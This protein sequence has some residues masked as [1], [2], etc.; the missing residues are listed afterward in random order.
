MSLRRFFRRQAWD[1]ECA[2]ELDAYLAQEID[3]NLARGMTTEQART[4]AY[5]KLGNPTRIREEIY[6][7]NSVG[8]L[9]SIWQDLRYGARLLRRNPTFA[10]VAVLTLALGTGA[11]SAIF[12]LVNAVRLRTLPVA[13][14][15]ELVEVRVKVEHGLTGAFLGRRPSLSNPLWERVRAEQRV[16]T[17]M[18]AWGATRWNL[19]SGGEVRRAQGMY[20]SGDYFSTLG[21]AAAVGRTIL[22]SD[23][24][25]GCAAPGAVISDSFWRRDYGADPSIVG[26]QILL[27]GHRVDILGVTP[28]SFFGTEVGRSF[29]VAM[30]ICAEPM[31]TG[32]RSGID[33]PDV[34]FLAAFGRLKPGVTIERATAQLNAISSGIFAT[35]V[36]PRYDAADA[37][38]YTQATLYAQPAA[39]GVSSLR[40]NYDDSLSILL[41]VTALV[42]LIA[43]A[44]LANL[45]LARGSA[46]EREIAI[47]LAIGATRERIVRQLLSESLLIAALGAAAGM[48]LA[49]WFSR[50]LVG[51]L[52][53]DGNQLFVDLTPDWRVFAFTAGVAVLACV[54]FGLAPAVRATR[55]SPGA[56]MKGGS[57]GL[58]DSRE[59][60]GVRRALVS[61]QVALSVVLVV[62]ALLFARTLLNLTRLD[63]GFRQDGVLVASVDFRKAGLTGAALETA[64]ND[65]RDRLAAIPGVDGVARAY[66]TPVSGNFWNNRIAIRGLP[67]K[68]PI[69]NFNSVDVEYFRVLSTPIVAGRAFDER[70]TRA[71]PKVAVVSES[72]VRA[73]MPKADALGQSF[74]ITAPAGEPQPSYQIVG[75]VR[76]TKYGSLRES[77]APIAFLS[78]RQADEPDDGPNYVMHASTTLAA[79]SAAATR[80]IAAMNP[81]LTVQYQTLRAQLRAS[82]LRERLMATLSGFFGGLAVLIATVGLY[83]V[84]SY[85]V[86]RR[87]VEIGIRMALGADRGSVVR[88]I[89]R[90]AAWLLLAGAA[91]GVALTLYAGR[92]AGALL[93]D[94][95]PSDP[96][97]IALA[98]A[99]LGSVCLL[100]SWLPARRA[101]RLHPTAALRED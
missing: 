96:S 4:A 46:R 17:S 64:T 77:F 36:S 34:W 58:T 56:S 94:L 1:A 41:G 70:D 50:F 24:V 42:L 82:L 8:P 88:L 29:D 74:Q 28:P 9:E 45:M 85:S 80:T 63:P 12:Q 25:R 44:N 65:L 26:R 75:V 21:V 83:G 57:R 72:F 69:V 60:F 98:L 95:R 39:T 35:T 81:A 49:S 97:T 71:T 89:V 91:A 27:D 11:N 66:T 5:R 2:R 47:R 19:A 90:E 43:C 10:I 23:D 7:M 22:P 67:Q 6:T 16:F 31:F 99:G 84:M 38:D 13:G 20:V 79:V 93:Y 55:T 68:G 30:P 92:A 15:D 52:S 61:L 40:A 48:L 78:V 14:A 59:R 53:A 100:A 37:R 62:G 51:F 54:I 76:D 18:L 3:D 32:E 87:R 101:A 33:K 86:A 73:Y